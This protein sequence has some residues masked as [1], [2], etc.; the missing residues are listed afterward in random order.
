MQE[1]P[2]FRGDIL[3]PILTQGRKAVRGIRFE[4]ISGGKG[5]V[6]WRRCMATIRHLW[7]PRRLDAANGR[8][9][10]PSG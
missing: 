7:F 1:D 4:S 9:T 3:R 8:G 10:K 2:R 5:H 6:G